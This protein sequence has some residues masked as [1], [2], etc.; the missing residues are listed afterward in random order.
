MRRQ[1]KARPQPSEPRDRVLRLKDIPG[2]FWYPFLRLWSRIMADEA[3]H[4]HVQRERGTCKFWLEPVA[5]AT[6]HRFSER[7]LAR[8]RLIILEN[9]G[10]II[11]AWNEHCGR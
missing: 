3:R 7:E 1:K 11:G 6:S 2:A 9:H 5:L 4:V 8:I 10:T